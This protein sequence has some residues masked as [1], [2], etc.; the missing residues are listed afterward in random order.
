[1][2]LYAPTMPPTVIGATL[3]VAVE[4]TIAVAAK[5]DVAVGPSGCMGFN[6]D[7]GAGGAG[8]QG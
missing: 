5:S 3:A 8:G 2:D 4:S 1:M 7:G 6:F